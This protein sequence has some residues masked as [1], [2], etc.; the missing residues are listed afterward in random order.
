M[1]FQPTENMPGK[2][3]KETSIITDYTS[4]YYKMKAPNDAFLDR[5]AGVN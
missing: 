3:L 5:N 2:R 4:T 1:H